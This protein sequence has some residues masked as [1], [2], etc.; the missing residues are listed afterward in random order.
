MV[1]SDRAAV[2]QTLAYVVAEARAA[3]P[4]ALGRAGDALTINIGAGTGAG[5][6]L[7][8]G[9]DARHQTRVRSGE[10]GGRT[11]LEARVVRFMAS[12]RCL[13]GPAAAPERR[14]PP[15]ENVAVIVRVEDGR[16]LGVG[17]PAPAA[18]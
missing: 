8:V 10:N 17:R 14:H 4:V 2:D 12:A 15:G 3:A 5:N 1:G 9:Y 6:V 13:A 11:L 16:V 7:L 18:S